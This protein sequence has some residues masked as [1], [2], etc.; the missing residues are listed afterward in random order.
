MQEVIARFAAFTFSTFSTFFDMNR[1]TVNE[2]EQRNMNIDTRESKKR[3]LKEIVW[4]AKFHHRL[5]LGELLPLG[6]HTKATL[7][8]YHEGMRNGLLDAARVVKDWV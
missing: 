8:T 1:M 4:R 2:I 7:R 3:A 6:R 5:F